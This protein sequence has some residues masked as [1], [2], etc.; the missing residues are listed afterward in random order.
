MIL[1]LKASIDLDADY[2]NDKKLEVILNDRTV[3]MN[4]G[5]QSFK[6]NDDMLFR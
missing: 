4:I 3:K 6:W 5:K 2:A 1:H